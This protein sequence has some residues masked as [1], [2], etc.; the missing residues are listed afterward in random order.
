MIKDIRNVPYRSKLRETASYRHS[1]EIG[2]KEEHRVFDATE[3]I[4]ILKTGSEG[5][6]ET[7]VFT[8]GRDS[9]DHTVDAK[10]QMEAAVQ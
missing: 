9:A 2:R 5:I 6:T 10:L 7:I 8:K 4:T 3:C 1:L